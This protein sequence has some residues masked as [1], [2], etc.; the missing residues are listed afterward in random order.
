MISPRYLDNAELGVYTPIMSKQQVSTPSYAEIAARCTYTGISRTMRTI[1]KLFDDG[2]Q[3]C[4]ISAN[5]FT[6]LVTLAVTGAIT[7]S[8]LAQQLNT[9]RTTL[10][11]NLRVLTRKALISVE[12]GHDQRQRVIQL[13]VRGQKTLEAAI[14]IWEALQKQVQSQL[15]QQRWQTLMDS[16]SEL[17][18]SQG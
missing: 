11:R 15:G 17:T 4:D 10:T 1:T 16:L 3:S 2:F 6:M 12:R 13:T 5:Q 7:L 14:P 8:Q 9:D 18:K